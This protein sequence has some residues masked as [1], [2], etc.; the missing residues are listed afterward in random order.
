MR[1]RVRRVEPARGGRSRRAGCIAVCAI[2]LAWS[3]P[4][5]AQRVLTHCGDRNG[6]GAGFGAPVMDGWLPVDAP[7]PGVRGQRADV[8]FVGDAPAV[9]YV[10]PLTEVFGPAGLEL[11]GERHEWLYVN[12]F[13]HVSLHRSLDHYIGGLGL[14]DQVAPELGPIIAPFDSSISNQLC[15]PPDEGASIANTVHWCHT[16]GRLVVTWQQVVPTSDDCDA[17]REA[18][19][20]KQ[21]NSFQLVIEQLDPPGAARPGDFAIEFRYETCD[22]MQALP[23]AR[24]G[25]A[26]IHVPDVAPWPLARLAVFAAPP[27]DIDGDGSDTVA[28]LPDLCRAS[29]TNPPYPGVFRFEVKAGE[30]DPSWP[31]VRTD[32]D[33]D[34]LVPAVDNCED[35]PNLGQRDLDRDGLGDRCDEDRDGDAV[36]DAQDNC[37][38]DPN[39]AQYNH[40]GDYDGSRPDRWCGIWD[41]PYAGDDVHGDACDPDRDGDGIPNVFDLCPWRWNQPKEPGNWDTQPDLDGDGFG[42]AC[43]HDRDGDGWPSPVYVCDGIIPV[44]GGPSDNCPTRHNPD[45]SDID[46]DGLGDACDDDIDGDGIPQ[47]CEELDITALAAFAAVCPPPRA[48][49]APLCLRGGLDGALLAGTGDNCPRLHNPAQL[50]GDG[51]GLG[52]LCDRSP[53]IMP[54]AGDAEAAGDRFWGV[55]RRARRYEGR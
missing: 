12:L 45:Q 4:A 53:G 11:Y 27:G 13:G 36:A 37:P 44:T 40:A 22:W 39:P 16:P 54:S 41:D 26:A 6:P 23:D 15:Q 2:V 1:E 43:D 49:D 50:D 42:D 46:G 19:R 24:R 20:L 30:A 17:V 8:E 28:A 3:G 33:R 52:D 47:C 7:E 38:D 10:V 21:T 9:P 32:S 5:A 29:N 35:I 14:D 55:F 34:G 25:W 18:A 48:Q 31:N 51:D